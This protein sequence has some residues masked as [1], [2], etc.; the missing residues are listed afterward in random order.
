MKP[1]ADLKRRKAALASFRFFCEVYFRRRFNKLWSK[2]HLKVIAEMEEVC[3]QGRPASP[4]HAAWHRKDVVDGDLLPLVFAGRPARIRAPGRIGQDQRGRDAH[5]HQELK[6]ESNELLAADFP[7]EVGPF[8]LLEG[9]PRACNGQRYRGKRTRILIRQHEIVF[10]TIPQSK[11]SGAILRVAGI[12]GRIRGAKFTRPDGK[13]IR[14]SL[15][16][17]DDPQTDKSAKSKEMTIDREKIITAAVKGLAGVGVR[18]GMVMPCTVI[19]ANDL[20]DRF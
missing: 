7:R 8:V 16:V 1:I 2:D 19:V 14:P 6:L 10:A 12:T 17:L 9:E 3:A 18:L 11:A 4:C 20:A 13:N 15:I 5:Q